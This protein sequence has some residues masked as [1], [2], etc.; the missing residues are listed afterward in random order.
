M[1]I[2]NEDFSFLPNV[3]IRSLPIEELVLKEVT[4]PRWLKTYEVA[5][6]SGEI[7]NIAVAPLIVVRLPNL[8]SEELL[9]LFENWIPV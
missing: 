7:C 3:F 8:G 5:K 9:K 1:E 4:I 6:W 2:L